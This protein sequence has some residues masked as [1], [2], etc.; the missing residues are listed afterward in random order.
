MRLNNWILWAASIY[1]VGA[2][3]LTP[4]AASFVS[5]LF[6]GPVWLYVSA[7]IFVSLI[8]CASLL[9]IKNFALFRVKYFATEMSFK[10]H[11]VAAVPIFIFC[12]F[13]V[14][15]SLFLGNH[16]VSVLF[17]HLGFV[18]SGGLLQR[19]YMQRLRGGEKVQVKN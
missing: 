11:W 9:L 17:W 10:S 2:A 4:L 15:A 16:L 14:G 7:Q 6:G 18:F 3:W 1:L 12:L 5:N 19:Y 8:V 13:I